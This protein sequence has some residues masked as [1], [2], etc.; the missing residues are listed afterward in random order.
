[1]STAPA[2]YLELLG[3]PSDADQ[4]AI[5]AA[6]RGAFRLWIGRSNAPTPE[7]RAEAAEMIKRLGEAEAVLLKGTSRFAPAPVPIAEAPDPEPPA[8]ETDAAPE[9]AAIPMHPCPSCKAPQPVPSAG[10]RIVCSE[11]GA[12]WSV[13]RCPSCSG[14]L[15]VLEEWSAWTCP[16]CGYAEPAPATE[17]EP[18]PE[19]ESEPEWESES[20]VIA[21]EC[22]KCGSANRIPR[23]ATGYVC[24]ACSRRH[25][26]CRCG[27][28]TAVGRMRGKRWKCASCGTLNAKIDPGAQSKPADRDTMRLIQDVLDEHRIKVPGVA[29]ALAAQ[30]TDLDGVALVGPDGDDGVVAV[31]G[32]NAAVWWTDGGTVETLDLG[33]FESVARNG[34]CVVVHGR[35]DARLC[36][37]AASD[38]HAWRWVAH[39]QRL[40][41]SAIAP[42]GEQRGDDADIEDARDADDSG[43]AP[44]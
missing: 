44:E 26:C 24:A 34:R 29:A 35:D 42:Y 8:L 6:L 40:G 16:R 12:P 41:L 43:Q 21:V 27:E 10:V 36:I 20:E 11:C 25:L 23:D 22:I 15:A 4:D 17:P 5:D 13:V 38:R 1:V 28:F 9:R 18:E 31:S 30:V 33:C 32:R 37:L 3:L 19:P 14:G 2:E 7:K 39:M